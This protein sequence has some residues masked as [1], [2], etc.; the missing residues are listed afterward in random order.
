MKAK[1]FFAHLRAA[2]RQSAARFSCVW[3]LS[4]ALFGVSVWNILIDGSF[5]EAAPQLPERAMYAL[6]VGLAAAVFVR[7]LL[8]RLAQTG[9]ALAAWLAP[10]GAAGAALGAQIFWK[11][12]SYV[13]M[14]MV[15]FAL[16]CV[17]AA[18][19]LLY[20]GENA[21]TLFAHLVKSAV[22]TAAV[23]LVFMLGLFLC[24]WAFGAL[25]YEPQN[26]YKAYVIVAALV[27]EVGAVNLFLAYVPRRG[28]ALSI[29]KVYH[30]LVG[31]AALPVYLLL[32]VIL[33]GYCLKIFVTHTLP[34]GQMNWFASFALAGWVFFYLG[35]RTHASRLSRFVVRWGGA[36][37][38]P[39]VA[40]QCLCIGIRLAAYG[41][42]PARWASLACLAVGIFAVVWGT[43]GKKP[44]LLFLVMAAMALTVT[45]TPLN[46]L[47]VPQWNQ[48]ARLQ[49]VLKADGMLENGVITPKSADEVP[50]DDRV[51]ISSCYDYLRGSKARQSAFVK[52]AAADDF[53]A[54]Y[55]FTRQSGGRDDSF[56]DDSES[57]DTAYIYYQS[58]ANETGIDVQGYSRMYSSVETNSAEN[59]ALTLTLPDGGTRTIDLSDYLVQLYAKNGD[60]TNNNVVMEYRPDADTLVLLRSVELGVRDSK[61]VSSRCEWTVLTK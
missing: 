7:V 47:D 31:W 33:Y 54:V 18:V 30:T 38:V 52:T 3:P 34:Q 2:L 59:G 9:C 6:C 4:L 40:V 15:G 46:V 10:L 43:L 27:W 50:E 53:E 56:W 60:S 48:S 19:W 24:L 16:A 49:S 26:Y 61:I 51:R 23:A 55:G 32:L 8:E 35:L 44:G 12:S 11:D 42:T 58:P 5:L 25:I 39:V 17:C 1:E 22:F 20:D 45:C 13:L 36:V 29:P 28:E 14:A 37:L 21:D 57:D 41:L